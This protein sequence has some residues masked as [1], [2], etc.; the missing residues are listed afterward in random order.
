[1]GKEQGRGRAPPSPIRIG[2]GGAP[3]FLPPSFLFLPSPTPNRKKGE[4]YSRWELDSPPWARHPPWTAPSSVYKGVEE[5][6]GQGGWRA[7]RGSP[8]PTG[9]R[10]PLFPIRSR[11]AKEKEG[12]RKERGGGALPIRI[13]L[14]GGGAP[15]LAPFP[16]FPLRP[17]K[18]HIPPG[19][20]R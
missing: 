6:A 13:G 20:F 19:G 7:L 11:R 18:A 17:N 5:G 15:S 8:T 1:M 14:G 12:G 16:S 4:S 10:T 9:S 2:R 3:P